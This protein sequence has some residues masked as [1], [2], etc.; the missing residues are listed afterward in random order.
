MHLSTHASNHLLILL[1]VQS[2]SQTRQQRGRS[3]KFE[4]SW[5][6]QTNCEKVV[7]EAWG[8]ARE[9]RVGLV[10]IQEKL[11]EAKLISHN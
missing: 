8:K 11:N 2:F 4:E 3:F 9:E 6:L 7:Q 10:A 1:D 5:L